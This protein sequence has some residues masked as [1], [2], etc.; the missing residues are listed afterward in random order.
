MFATFS[1]SRLAF[2]ENVVVDPDRLRC[3]NRMARSTDSGSRGL[4]RQAI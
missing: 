3:R 4:E 2:R 1:K